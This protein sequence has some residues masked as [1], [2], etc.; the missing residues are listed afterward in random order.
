MKRRFF[1]VL[2]AVLMVVN[3]LGAFN[4]SFA[5][6]DVYEY[7]VGVD[8]GAI[9]PAF[10]LAFG[11]GDYVRADALSNAALDIFEAELKSALPRVQVVD[12]IT[13]LTPG[14][15]V[16]ASLDEIDK[17]E[18]MKYVSK[19]YENIKYDAPATLQPVRT[20]SR[21]SIQPMSTGAL[22]T[23]Y[24]FVDSRYTGKGSVVAVV[25]SMMNPN[26][27]AF[28]DV[29]K[30]DEVVTESDANAVQNG[31][32]ISK[33]IPFAWNYATND[34]KNLNPINTTNGHG[35]HVAGIA[36]GNKTLLMGMDWQG[37]APDAQL[38]LMNIA[39]TNRD[40]SSDGIL[41]A[42]GDALKL[43][44]NVVNMSLGSP[45]GGYTNKASIDMERVIEPLV[46]AG[47]V[48]AVAAGN[49]GDVSKLNISTDNPDLNSLA[50][51]A[52]SDNVLT[53]A[54]NLNNTEYV[55][56]IKCTTEKKV[57]LED[58]REGI[59][60]SKFEF[61]YEIC[62]DEGAQSG[63][64]K[65]ASSLDDLDKLN[66][67]D[68]VLWIGELGAYKNLTD[69]NK[70]KVDVLLFDSWQS[71]EGINIP[72]ISS[73]N[74]KTL[75]DNKAD[76]KKL[77]LKFLGKIKQDP[78]R[79][80]DFTSWGIAPEGSLKPD[81]SAP[82][83]RVLS[84]NNNKGLYLSQGTSMATPVVSGAV[85]IFNEYF[86]SS[87]FKALTGKDK[88]DIIKTILMNS[89]TPIR[90]GEMIASP[91]QQGAGMLNV[92]NATKIDFTV[93]DA[94]SNIASKF[95]GDV[96]DSINLNLKIKNWSGSAKNL[97]AR[98][99]IL[100]Q[101]NTNKK[102]EL[103]SKVSKT[104]ALDGINLDANGEITKDFNINISDVDV[105]A[106]QNGAFVDGFLY[107]N[108]GENEISFPFAS[109][110]KV[111][112]KKLSNLAAIEK[113]IY[114]FKFADESPMYWEFAQKAGETYWHYLSTHIQSGN[115]I[116]GV[117]NFDEIDEKVK[118]RA[119]DL[120]DAEARKKAFVATNPEFQLHNKSLIFSK[121]NPVANTSEFTPYIVALRAGKFK[122]YIKNG[123]NEIAPA[124]FFIEV[125]NIETKPF[126][127][128]NI[129][130]TTNPIDAM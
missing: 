38:L 89:A 116:A 74:V 57:T 72:I 39:S 71:S 22:N 118:Q 19:V 123:D 125:N 91:R 106:Y 75:Q 14:V 108:D 4:F 13:L 21:R 33:K 27:P 16:R 94:Q 112:G 20:R 23:V 41:N 90:N 102:M 113:P 40:F 3:C 60:T 31:S 122:T 56:K 61:E 95:V 88:A 10:T 97:T 25:D 109:F 34:H 7:I 52:N 46:N 117:K 26:H 6:G 37:V 92:D 80:S 76:I 105:S 1:S 63:E 11:E 17:I 129:S 44:S 8:V 110:K 18:L 111:N 121:N 15:V 101:N 53:V 128:Y 54:S 83:D 12:R 107:L 30:I 28:A 65:P 104:V 42:L 32:Y 47:I 70:A 64:Y 2:L 68:N 127:A 115:R 124:E 130:D 81:I 85:A 100:V 62:N 96:E 84:L 59:S 51:P 126:A 120:N 98:A 58:G 82:G 29:S 103:S 45:K 79:M 9:D 99:E 35:Q 86:K 66:T 43:R 50:N 36:A 78:N 69:E 87:P 55:N 119:Q 73:P 24:K 93:V 114:D 67:S 5:A 77:E 48:V 49:S